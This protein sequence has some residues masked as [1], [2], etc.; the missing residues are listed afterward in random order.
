MLTM[1]RAMRSRGTGPTANG[2]TVD[3]SLLCSII[4][5][6]GLCDAT[7]LLKLRIRS[8]PIRFSR[9][10]GLGR[11]G[12]TRSITS[13]FLMIRRRVAF[14]TT[15]PLVSRHSGGFDKWFVRRRVQSIHKYTG[16]MLAQ[17]VAVNT[18]CTL[19]DLTCRLR[20]T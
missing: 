3:S 6:D 13:I 18:T 2:L 9:S 7:P 20:A 16:P 15:M 11:N 12:T 17:L 8:L 1:I 19:W 4:V 14:M 10:P 5:I